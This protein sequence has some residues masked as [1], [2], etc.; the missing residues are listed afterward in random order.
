MSSVEKCLFKSS[1]D[2]LIGLF[3]VFYILS[4]VSSLYIFE[5]KSV[6]YWHKNWYRDY[7]N[8]IQSLESKPTH[9]GQLICDKEG[10]NIKWRKDNLFNKLCQQNWTATHKIM[11][12]EHSFTP[13]TKINSQR[14]KNLNVRLN[15][16]KILEANTG[17]TLSDKNCCNI[18]WIHLLG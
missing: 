7:W 4:F 13:Y 18:F 6:K 3:G 14:I 1:V 16:L 15:T 5:I 11:K 2:F 12:L 10:K 9:Y 8:R 17:R